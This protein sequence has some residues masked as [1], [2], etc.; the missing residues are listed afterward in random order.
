MIAKAI[1]SFFFVLLSSSVALAAL[2]RLSLD[3]FSWAEQLV[4]DG[5]GSMFVSD[6]VSG[7]L[8]RVY[9][10]GDTYCKTVHLEEG[11][12]Q[13]GGLAVTPDGSTLYAGVTFIDK[14]KGLVK[15]STAPTAPGKFSEWTLVAKTL[16]QPNGMAADWNAR[17]LYC[18]D[19]GT[20]SEEGGSVITIHADTGE[21]QLIR[22][23]MKLPDGAWFDEKTSL[24]YIGGLGS[25]KIWVYDTAKGVEVGE[26]D[27]LN[28]LKGI[29]ML[30]DISLGINGTDT[31]NLGNTILL[32]AD[33]TG[34]SIMK[35]KLDG[36]FF[37]AVPVPEGVELY[38]PTSVRYGKGPGFCP[39]SL[40]LTEG[41][42][43]TKRQTKRRVLQL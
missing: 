9:L 40:Y 39:N 23:Q 3:G 12:I 13:F 18:T 7:Q 5:I 14:S 29:H 26:F 28:G 19:E 8:W 24:L 35:F 37:E 20:G 31:T 34:K 27:G 36:S 21:V 11:F 42:G 1:T 17:L 43:A 2:P 38:E 22:D 6:A 10:C 16:H 41:G 30:D 25:M 15:T 33:F 4:F 32:G